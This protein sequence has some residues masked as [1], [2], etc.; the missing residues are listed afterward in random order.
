[1]IDQA[2]IET[3]LI[4]ATTRGKAALVATLFEK[5]SEL[6]LDD[7]DREEI[8]EALGEAGKTAALSPNTIRLLSASAL[9]AGPAMAG[10]K[11]LARKM[12]H[13][14]GL[15][16][17]RQTAPELFQQEPHRAQAIYDLVHSSAPSIATNP[18]VMG[19]I[20]RQMMAMPSIDLGTASA[21]HGLQR[22][23]PPSDY[24]AQLAKLKDQTG[25]MALLTTGDPANMPVAP[26]VASVMVLAA[27]RDEK[28]NPTILDWGRPA[29]K[30]ADVS[31]IFG[32]GGQGTVMDQAN[33]TGAIQPAVAAAP[34]VPLDLVLQELMAK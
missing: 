19:D 26:K 18:V 4:E 30:Q 13:E 32:S 16:A 6:Q 8:L 10:A 25:G 33:Q 7:Y 28:G 15:A 14:R 9:L 17:V 21:I 3:A 1:M 5:L 27:Y 2:G 34:M 31:H 11:M 12:S 23:V 29:I 22:S 24:G 20:M